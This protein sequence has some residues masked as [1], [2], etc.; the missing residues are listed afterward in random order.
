MHSG[1]YSVLRKPRCNGHCFVANIEVCP[2]RQLSIEAGLVDVIR[3]SSAQ[4][5]KMS[6]R[7]RLAKGAALQ[8][9]VSPFSA[10][11]CG[12][13]VMKF[14]RAAGWRSSNHRTIGHRNAWNCRRCRSSWQYSGTGGRRGHWIKLWRRR[15]WGFW[16]SGKRD[17]FVNRIVCTF[18]CFLFSLISF[19]PTI[20]LVRESTTAHGGIERSSRHNTGS[21]SLSSS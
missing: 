16:E 5:N 15:I 14:R 1:I 10:A 18:F 4:E 8:S 7:R 3:L 21:C 13:G 11:L 9:E 19:C 2:R 20:I 6:T 17:C 12:R